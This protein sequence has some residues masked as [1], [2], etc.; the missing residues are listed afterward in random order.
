MATLQRRAKVLMLNKMNLNELM[1]NGAN[2]TLAVSLNDLTQLVELTI[3]KT[4]HELEQQIADEKT[5]RYI[6]PKQA[7]EMLSVNLSSLWRWHKKGY[8]SPI[9]A[10]GKR[11][12]RFSDIKKVLN[13]G[14]CV[15]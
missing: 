2:V 3:A 9:E 4:K 15:K 13:G 12:Y 5:E 6:T 10:G 1:A 14:G 11:L 8:L 7:S